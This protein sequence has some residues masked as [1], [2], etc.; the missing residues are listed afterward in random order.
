MWNNKTLYAPSGT[1]WE[2][3]EVLHASIAPA[4]HKV[5][6]IPPF[7]R[8]HTLDVC[9]SERN[10]A[11]SRPTALADRRK[12]REM[13]AD[14]ASTST[15]RIGL[16]AAPRLSC[17]ADGRWDNTDRWCLLWSTPKALCCTDPAAVDLSAGPLSHPPSRSFSQLGWNSPNRRQRA[18]RV[19]RFVDVQFDYHLRRNLDVPERDCMV[20]AWNDD[21]RE[22]WAF[23]YA[24]LIFKVGRK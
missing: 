1:A 15:R 3:T 16:C 10:P 4:T 6:I 20:K 2:R 24:I 13:T 17:W 12:H 8:H 5:L 23:N 19:W 14:C 18:S 7:S 11:N 21:A 22:S 9:L